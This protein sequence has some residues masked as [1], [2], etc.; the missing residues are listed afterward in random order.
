MDIWH[1]TLLAIIQGLTEFLPVSS[2]A[3]LILL[4][5]LT[6]WEDQGL[7]FDVA[8]HLGSLIA[9]LMYFRADL[10]PLLGSWFKSLKTRQLTPESRLVWGVGIGTIPAGVVGLAISGF[11][12]DIYLRSPLIIAGATILFGFLLGVADMIGERERDEL[13]LRW[14]DIIFIGIA[15]ALALIPGTSRSGITI[16]AALFLGINR[17]AAA[18]FSFLLAIPIIIL[19]GGAETMSLINENVVVDWT[20][21]L[22]AVAFSTVSAYLCIHVFIRLLDRIGMLPFVV[23][24]FALGI[25]LFM[26]FI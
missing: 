12:L 5:Q 6:E 18:R 4:P 7:A 25:I 21:L 13:S 19:A 23:Y 22:L 20:A 14:Q 17:K 10:G 26:V 8:V 9:V 2:S 24:R 15:Q 11:D 1:I 3:H 16:T